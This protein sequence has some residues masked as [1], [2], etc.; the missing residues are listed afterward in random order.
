MNLVLTALFSAI[1]FL[2]IKFWQLNHELSTL[3][4]MVAKELGKRVSPPKVEYK[5]HVPSNES[6]ML[7][8][9]FCGKSQ[10]EVKTLIA[11]PNI[12][13]CDECVSLCNEIIA[14]QSQKESTLA[15]NNSDSQFSSTQAP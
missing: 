12:Y 1:V 15:T 10:R 9:S 8:C 5:K 7:H 14:K 6:N 3:R 13:V 4:S 2:W 11:G